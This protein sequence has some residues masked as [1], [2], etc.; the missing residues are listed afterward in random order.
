MFEGVVTFFQGFIMLLSQASLRAVLWRMLGLLLFLML[1]LMGG[2]FYLADYLAALWLPVGEE[3]YWQIVAWL[4]WTLAVSLSLISGVVGFT[5]L[6]TAAIAPWLDT[7]AT[8]TEEILGKTSVENESSWISQSL[9]SLAN[10]IRPLFGLLLLGSVA[11][12]FLLIPVIGAFIA[13]VIWAYAGIRFLNFELFDTQASR[14]GL[15]FSERKEEMAEKPW[16]WLG[17]GGI[18]LLLMMLPLFNL[19]VI[20]AAVVALARKG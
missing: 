7:L 15:T 5:A 3:W 4:A 6:G 17:F 2:V 1:L 9:G 14:A 13:T 10:S 12:L 18:A 19:L 11:L 8:R 20:P 16:F